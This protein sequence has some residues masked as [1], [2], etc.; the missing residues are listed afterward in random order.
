MNFKKRE[1]GVLEAENLKTAAETVVY[2][3]VYRIF[4][5]GGQDLLLTL[6]RGKGRAFR[7]EKFNFTWRGT[8]RN[9]KQ[10]NNM[11]TVAE[12][13]ELIVA[14]PWCSGVAQ[15]LSL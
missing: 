7:A 14:G 8:D 13:L 6:N 12:L 2:R 9:K 3:A 1:N 4:I 5:A 15:L 10:G 11:V